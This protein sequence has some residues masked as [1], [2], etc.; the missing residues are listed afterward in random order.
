MSMSMIMRQADT[1]FNTEMDFDIVDMI[2]VEI[3]V[4]MEGGVMEGAAMGSAYQPPAG[5][6]NHGRD[7]P[8]HTRR[9]P[10]LA[11]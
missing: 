8:H 11:G 9:C 3:D 4:S 1:H 7:V 2:D 5:F 10:G 6:K